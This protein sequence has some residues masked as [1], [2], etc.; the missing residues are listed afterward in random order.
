M[1]E[2]GPHDLDG[3]PSTPAGPRAAHV[4]RVLHGQ[5]GRRHA[6]GDDHAPQAGLHPPQWSGAKRE[7]DAAR[8]LHS[9]R[10]RVDVDFD[11]Q[12]SRISDGAVHQEP[13]LL[14]RPRLS[15]GALSV[16]GGHRSGA[17]SGRDPALPAGNESISR[18]VRD[19]V[20]ACRAKPCAAERR[21]C[22]RSTWRSSRR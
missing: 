6:D 15:D 13:Q 14:L 5:M 10:Q 9:Q 8:A 12:R 22:T 17:A 2:S 18:R 3:W 11:R 1:D 20:G 7:G 16:L 4:A 21:R 19:E